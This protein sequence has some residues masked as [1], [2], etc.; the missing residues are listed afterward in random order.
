MFYHNLSS[1]LLS[2]EGSLYV[3]KYVGLRDYE[4][5]SYIPHSY[6]QRYSGYK[7]REYSR[8]MQSILFVT[9]LLAEN[10]IFYNGTS[11]HRR[12]LNL[13]KINVGKRK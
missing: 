3:D 8:N 13:L 9:H 10:R 4:H 5:T 1:I 2:N 12:K 7:R 11:L 6:K